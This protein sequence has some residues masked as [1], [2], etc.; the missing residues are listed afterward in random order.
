MSTRAV[1]ARKTASGWR[2]VIHVYDSAPWEL[3]NFLLI[4]VFARSGDLHGLVQ[5]VVDEGPGGWESF[6]SSKRLEGEEAPFFHP[7]DLGDAGWLEWFYL[8]DVARR[9]LDVFCGEAPNAQGE[10]KARTHSLSF[11]ARGRSE[12]GLFEA[13]E[14]PWF[15]IPEAQQWAADDDRAASERKAVAEHM[16]QWCQAQG[17]SLPD[18]Q[19]LVAE[20]L[21][22]AIAN[23]TWAPP[24]PR[25]SKMEVLRQQQ[26]AG[27][28]VNP[29]QIAAQVCDDQAQTLEQFQQMLTMV[30]SSPADAM[31]ALRTAAGSGS[32]E[33]MPVPT[34]PIRQSFLWGEDDRYWRVELG[35]ITVLYAS[36]CAFRQDIDP[37]QLVREGGFTTIIDDLEAVM[38]MQPELLVQLKVACAHAMNPDRDLEYSDDGEVYCVTRI[39]DS[40]SPGPG[41]GS[42]QRWTARGY[43]VA[44][45]DEMLVP[46]RGGLAFHL[47]LDWVRSGQVAE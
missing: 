21:A 14:E 27:Q 15:D 18:A 12:P 32:E 40:D 44:V 1:V 4:E 9:R 33:P 37:L 34:E 28:D 17:R 19:Q 46:A 22:A 43:E 10:S 36:G 38:A 42:L 7:G 5:A 41:E 8:F 2:G 23:A 25:A 39:V 30:N 47:V 11:D 26:L 3:G 6:I 35:D 31:T 16:Q 24:E 20:A 45:G 29:Q 13:P